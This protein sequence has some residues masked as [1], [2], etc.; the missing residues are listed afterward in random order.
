MDTLRIDE[1][2]K[3]SVVIITEQPTVSIT[4]A[5]LR[6]RAGGAA[7]ILTI[8]A[9]PPPGQRSEIRLDF[10]DNK[11]DIDPH[12]VILEPDRP[13]AF[14][15]VTADSETKPEERISITLTDVDTLRIDEANNQ[16]VVIITDQ[17]VITAPTAVPSLNPGNRFKDCDNCPQMVA[18]P[19]GSFLM[20]SPETEEGRSSTEGPVHRVTINYPFAVGVHEI[21]FNEWDYCV[22][23]GGCR[24]Y[25][26]D[27]EDWGRGRRPVIK[28]SWHDAKAYVCWLSQETGKPYRLLTEAEW[29]Y[30]AR[31]GTTTLYHFGD[32]ISPTQANYSP[33][34]YDDND[35]WV[36][37]GCRDQTIPVGSFRANKFGLHDM[38]G[39]VYEWVEDCWH[40]SYTGAPSDGSAWITGGDCRVR[41]SRG[42]SWDN[43]PH[44]LRSATRFWR[45]YGGDDLGFRVAVTLTP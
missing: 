44:L 7:G 13:S 23:Q 37:P 34:H 6:L 33:W 10:D 2:N 28:V 4:P 45:Y 5:E 11:I 32:T 40:N 15:S 29:E 22:Q 43:F 12:P 38:H 3:Q 27:D 30:A 8:T 25:R 1:A 19:P 35:E 18:V 31:A 20:G 26:P 39:N 21:T 9:E 24:G 14:V 36:C 41:V 17:C 42:G 16:S